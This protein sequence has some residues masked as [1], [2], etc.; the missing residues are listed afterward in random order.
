MSTAIVIAIVG[1]ESTGKTSLASALAERLPADTGLRCAW[2]G[3]WLR[4]WCDEHGRTPR[5][6]EQAQIA[7]VQARHIAEAAQAHDIVVADTT[8]LMTA[9]YSDLLFDDPSLYEPALRDQR[10]YDLTLLTA[11]D[12]PW[13]A[14]G[15]QRDGPHVRTPVDDKVRAALSG[16][17][18]AFSVV[19]GYGEDRLRNALNAITPLLLQRHVAGEGLFTRLHEREAAMPRWEWVC[20]ACDV[21]DCEHRALAA[22]G[23]A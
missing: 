4:D 18:V 5:A 17:D 23:T 9:V 16:A 14:D 2:V 15:H 1:A 12:L 10:G 3:E 7:L 22:R 20:E 21:P 8:P 11:L 19:S 6:D 13:V